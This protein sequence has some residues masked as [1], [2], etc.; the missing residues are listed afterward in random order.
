MDCSIEASF[1]KYLLNSADNEEEKMLNQ[2]GPMELIIVLAIILLLF[3]AGRITRVGSELG[4]AISAFR[5]GVKKEL[6]EEVEDIT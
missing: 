2:I 3:G 1:A 4:S 5:E 6:P